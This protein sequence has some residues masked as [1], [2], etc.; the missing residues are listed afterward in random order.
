MRKWWRNLNKQKP[1]AGAGP[2]EWFVRHLQ[3]QTQSR[4]R[5][6]NPKHS[7]AKDQYRQAK[8]LLDW[9]KENRLATKSAQLA[10]LQP[11]FCA[12][13]AGNIQLND[14]TKQLAIVKRIETHL[15]MV[16]C[17]TGLF[18]MSRWQSSENRKA[19]DLFQ[20]LNTLHTTDA[21]LFDK[22]LTKWI[23]DEFLFDAETVKT[24]FGLTKQQ[25]AGESSIKT[26]KP[27]QA[28]PPPP[29]PSKQ[30]PPKIYFRLATTNTSQPLRPSSFASGDVMAKCGNVK[31]NSKWPADGW[32]FPCYKCFAP[33]SKLVS[34]IVPNVFMCRTCQTKTGV[35]QNP[36]SISHHKCVRT[37]RKP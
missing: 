1:P 23:D 30:A 20:A 9:A 21:G 29:V 14:I 22:L 2:I 31:D 12:I 13:A 15:A 26:K 27:P 18:T 17:K 35:A 3:S 33:T 28:P 10:W 32:V 7:L 36:L 25:P 34:A 16:Q 11:L 5:T 4:I 37:L 24:A 19:W 6:R 8:Q